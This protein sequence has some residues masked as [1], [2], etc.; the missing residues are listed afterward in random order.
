MTTETEK[1]IIKKISEIS[2]I[3]EENLVPTS[4]L[5]DD[6]N[7]SDIEKMDL[8]TTLFRDLKFTLPDDMELEN[9]NTVQDIIEFIENNTEEL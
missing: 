3:A 9:I 7:L 2:G 4:D 5:K 1:N 8:I 6:M